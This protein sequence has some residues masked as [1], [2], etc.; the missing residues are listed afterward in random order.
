[1]NRTLEAAAY[2]LLVELASNN[3]QWP[4]K[5]SRSKPIARVMELDMASKL[6]H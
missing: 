4:A 3:Y 1:M 5:R 2:R 6:N